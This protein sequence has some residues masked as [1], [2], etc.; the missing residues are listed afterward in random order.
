MVVAS[1]M[2]LLDPATDSRLAEV[3]FAAEGEVEE[4]LLSWSRQKNPQVAANLIDAALILGRPELAEEAAAFLAKE[5][6][7][8]D[9]S[10]H[11][12]DEVLNPQA[13]STGIIPVALRREERHRQIATLRR[14]LRVYPR[15]AL[16]WVDLAREF[17]GLGLMRKAERS[18]RAAIGLAPEN[19]FILRSASR[20]FLH[21]RDPE[22]AHR[23]LIRA[24][25]TRED[26]WLLAAE[27]V[28]ASAAG[29]TSRLVKG[30]ISLVDSNKMHPFHISE[31][32]S[33]IGTLEH[34]AGN[35]RKVRRFFER[36]FLSPTE[37][38]VAQAS[39]VAR[40]MPGFDLPQETLGVPRAFEAQAW[41][42]AL[43]EDYETAVE[44]SWDWLRDEPFATRSARFGSWVA[45]NAMADFTVASELMQA[46]LIANPD[47]PRLLAQLF[48]CRASEGDI[49]EAERIF[50]HLEDAIR[51][52]PD[53]QPQAEWDVLLAADRGLLAFRNGD[54]PSGRKFYKEAIQIAAAHKLSEFGATA[55]LNFV[56]EEAR[57]DPSVPVPAADLEKALKAYPKSTAGVMKR[58][59]QQ[60]PELRF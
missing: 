22:T 19:R 12:A 5:N 43:D 29:R 55:Y 15:D 34:S 23:I 51:S 27:I 39:W 59:L 20:F 42:S 56:R 8:S 38:A 53:L 13:P 11:M 33:A 44:K 18:L 1:R 32:A 3:P 46:A 14:R 7:F 48:Y 45:S 58:F 28:A 4:L 50:A 35:R 21:A 17:A 16:S 25:R 2:G 26:P 31:L 47:D 60:I 41:E 10:L 37:N 54:T 6:P 52:H 57:L 9:I 30:G 49:Q 40:H 24:R 36:A